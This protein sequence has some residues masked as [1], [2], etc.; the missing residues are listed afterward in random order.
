MLASIERI[1]IISET[2]AGMTEEVTASVDEQ[3]KA[4]QLVTESS[5][6]LSDE[7]QGLQESINKFVIR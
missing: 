2:N 7:I 6:N 4:V 3:Q 1:A 5:N